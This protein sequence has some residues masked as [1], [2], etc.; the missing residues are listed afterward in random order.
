MKRIKA[1]NGYTIMQVTARDEKNGNGTAGEFAI[2]FS[3]DIRDYGVAYSYPEYDGLETL[4]QCEEICTAKDSVNYAKAR[5]LCEQESTAVSFEDI[6]QK[7]KEIEAEQ[8]APATLYLESRGGDIRNPETD[9]TNYRLSAVGRIPCKVNGEILDMYIEFHHWERYTYRRTNKRTGAPLKHPV[10]ELVNPHGLWIDTEYETTEE[11]N[12]LTWHPAFRCS[13]MEKE[14]HATNPTFTRADVLEVLN[15]YSVRRYNKV[16]VVD[17]EVKR[18]VDRL[19]G[20]REK[21]IIATDAVYSI[22]ETW[23][24]NHKVV[25]I[26]TRRDNKLAESFEVDLVTGRICG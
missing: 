11:R 4:E 25:R 24:D 14:A 7:L 13:T 8:E 12:G 15:R 5:E 22:G 1:M 9:L 21:D 2:Y 3:S 6:E 19:G 20:F 10:K 16:V 17:E 23:N 26:T 18:I